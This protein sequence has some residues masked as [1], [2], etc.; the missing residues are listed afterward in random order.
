MLDA[1]TSDPGLDLSALRAL[2]ARR[3][4][5]A[6]PQRV[7]GLL[8]RIESHLDEHLAVAEQMGPSGARLAEIAQSAFVESM[9]ASL[10]VLASVITVELGGKLGDETGR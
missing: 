6:D 7:S 10:L 9:N 4:G 3:A 1:M 5:V 2:R 8:E